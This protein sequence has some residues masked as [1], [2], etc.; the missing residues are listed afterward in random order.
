MCGSL[1]RAGNITGGA[2]GVVWLVGTGLD[3]TGVGL[4]AGAILQFG[5]GMAMG[6]GVVEVGAGEVCNMITGP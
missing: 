5:G 6:V 2:G 4:P 1:T 3:A